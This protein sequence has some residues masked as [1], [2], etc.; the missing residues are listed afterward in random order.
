[1][2]FRLALQIA[3][4]HLRSRRRQTILATLGIVI[5]G[6]IFALMV[7]ITEGQSGFLRDKII[8]ISPHIILTSDRLKP[9]VSQNLLDHEQGFVELR[10]NVP[11]STRKEVKPYTEVQAKVEKSTFDVIAVAPYV[12]LQGVF[13]NGTRYQ[14]VTV[15]GVD[16][17]REKNIG[18][19]ARDIR[20][21]RLSALSELPNGAVIG[22]GL[23]AK[24]NVRIG[25]DI[26]FV[27]PTGAIQPL[28]IAA[29]YESGVANADDRQ[30]YIN[31]SLGQTLRDLPRNSVTGLSIELRD[32]AGA[33]RVKEIVE[34][35][36]GYKAET[37][38]ETNAQILEFQGRQGITSR[39][40]VVFVF[41]TAAFG[42]S[43][44]L[45][46]IVLQKKQ[47]IAVMKSFGVSR[48]GVVAIFLL[49]GMIIGCIGGL[50]AALLGY[51]LARL[52]GSLN[53]VPKT[54]SSYVRFDRF[55]VSLDFG[56]YLF[57]FGFSVLMAMIAS[58][59]PARRAAKFAPVRVI[60]GEV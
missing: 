2:T 52:F 51:G 16:P 53:L 58:I 9:V 37:W 31:L 34:R 43:N 21:G 46:A 22:S 35:L 39:I 13:R 5:G 59:L 12:L 25:D 20:Q 24:L 44:T 11:P 55:P 47:D 41:V 50:L 26:S 49:E 1:M 48:G 54:S 8:D 57:T 4:R 56:I 3:L 29:I 6:G 32:I 19:L 15:R 30:G 18:K 45:V 33:A 28:K 17:E 36:T 40:L 7:A 14:T 27:T 38:E 10:R 60:R 23:A 42:I